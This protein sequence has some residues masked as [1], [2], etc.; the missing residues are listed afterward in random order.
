MWDGVKEKKSNMAD[1]KFFI[2][3]FVK[4]SANKNLSQLKLAY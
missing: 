3:F 2:V 4:F 1:E